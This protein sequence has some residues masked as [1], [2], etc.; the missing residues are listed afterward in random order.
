MSRAETMPTRRS[1]SSTTSRW[2]TPRLVIRRATSI[3][4]QVNKPAVAQMRPQTGIPE[5]LPGYPLPDHERCHGGHEG[6]MKAPTIQTERSHGTAKVS[7]TAPSKTGWR[8]RSIQNGM[9]V[10]FTLTRHTQTIDM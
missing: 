3:G 4:Q 5:P 7:A 9:V 6:G 1:P 10:Y 2:R 8:W